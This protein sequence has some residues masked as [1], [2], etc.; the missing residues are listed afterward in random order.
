[1]ADNG[2]R[3]STL[4]IELSERKLSVIVH[5]LFS[6]WMLAFIFEGQI[7]YSLAGSFDLDHTIKVFCG[8]AAVL[9]GLLICGFFVKTKKAAR[10]LFLYSY[11]FFAAVSIIFF[12]PPSALW[13]LGIIAGSFLAGCCVAAWGFYLKESTPKNERIKTAA[14]MLIFSNILM[15]LL[16]MTAIHLSP[17]AGLAFSMFLLLGAFLFALRLP[18]DHDTASPGSPDQ[19]KTP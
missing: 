9:T 14:D 1:M 5:S 2:G 8:I 11:P 18:A 12:F 13:T 19:K 17:Y 15:I 7:F 3:P 16:N 4:Y 10:C 6:A